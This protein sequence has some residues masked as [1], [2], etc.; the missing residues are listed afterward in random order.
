MAGEMS[1]REMSMHRAPPYN[2]PLQELFKKCGVLFGPWDQP[3]E[4]FS[5]R[6]GSPYPTLQYVDKAPGMRPTHV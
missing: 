6:R 1:G 2:R 3:V 4:A 5:Q